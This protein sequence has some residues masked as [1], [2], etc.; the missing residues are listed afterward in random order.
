MAFDRGIGSC[1][2]CVKLF[3]VARPVLADNTRE[4]CGEFLRA[5]VMKAPR[6]NG[7]EQRRDCR[8]KIVG[9]RQAETLGEGYVIALSAGARKMRAQY[10][11]AE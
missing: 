8:V 3:H 7:W 6:G 4:I 10:S 11:T 1:E 2:G 9:L 5:R